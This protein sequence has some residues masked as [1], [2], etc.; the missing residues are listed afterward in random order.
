MPP[1][2]VDTSLPKHKNQI[3]DYDKQK[4]VLRARVKVNQ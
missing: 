4:R 2:S 1:K 3:K